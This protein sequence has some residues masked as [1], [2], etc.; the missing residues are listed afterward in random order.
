M[1][2]E[3]KFKDLETA[4]LKQDE[5]DDKGHKAFLSY[6]GKDDTATDIILKVRF[7]WGNDHE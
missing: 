7:N 1:Y 6:K 5:L 4:R 3:F 2:H